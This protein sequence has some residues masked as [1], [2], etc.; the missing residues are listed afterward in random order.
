VVSSARRY[1]CSELTRSG[2]IDCKKRLPLPDVLIRL[3]DEYVSDPPGETGLHIAL[4]LF[5]GL[6]QRGSLDL[7]LQFLLLDSRELYTDELALLRR[8]LDWRELNPAALC[9]H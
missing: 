7:I 8:E 2:A 5:I 1:S 3:I 4:L 9:S 6:Y